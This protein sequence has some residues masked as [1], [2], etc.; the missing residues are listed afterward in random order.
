[1]RWL[2]LVVWKNG[3][4]EY[5][6]EGD[7]LAIFYSKLRAEQTRDFMLQGMEEEVSINKCDTKRNRLSLFHQRD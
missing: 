5:L 7:K 3:E 6:K 2:I 4:T 1:M